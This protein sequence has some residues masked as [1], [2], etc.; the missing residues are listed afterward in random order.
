MEPYEQKV[1]VDRIM[2]IDVKN[3]S[4]IKIIQSLHEEGSENESYL[5]SKYPLPE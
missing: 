1:Y 3:N 2:K 5:Q 4:R